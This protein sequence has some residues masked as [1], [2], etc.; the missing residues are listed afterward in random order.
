MG[1]SKI[2]EIKIANVA[3]L[4]NAKF[5]FDESGILNIK[6][7]NDSGKSAFLQSVAMNLINLEPKVQSKFIRHGADFFR[8]SILFDDGVEI[9][10]DKYINGQ[11][12]YEMRKDGELVYTTKEGR[13]LTKVNKVPDIIQDYLGLCMTDNGCINYQSRRDPLFLIDTTGS[14]NYADLHEA[15]K[16]EQ[17]SRANSIANSDKNKAASEVTEIEADIQ[18]KEVR[19]AELNNVSEWLIENL[20]RLESIAIELE[21]R[22]EDVGVI[23]E[24]SEDIENRKVIPEVKLVHVERYEAVSSI[25]RI[26]GDIESIPVYPSVQR[27]DSSRLDSISSISKSVSNLEEVRVLPPISLVDTDRIMRLNSI[28]GYI[29][30][31]KELSKTYIPDIPKVDKNN[32]DAI[33]DLR[34][35]VASQKELGECVLSL[36]KVKSELKS[37]K[38]TL[39]V[40]VEKAREQGH[41]FTKCSNCGSF[42]EV[43]VGGKS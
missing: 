13:T 10:R 5:V 2:K 31:L 38:Q 24:L 16:L 25:S 9:T 29:S 20:E 4:K 17:V 15:L 18:S 11:S 28:K 36:Q 34:Q 30:Q 21:D 23:K 41:I 3:T 14:Q 19:K 42:I 35:L 33:S 6:G 37:T 39:R 26:V 22:K 40:K 1:Y 32:L 43:N 8:V 27:V 12:L 7:Y